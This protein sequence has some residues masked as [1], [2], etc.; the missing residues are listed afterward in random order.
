M[1]STSAATPIALPTMWEIML[2]RSS[3]LVYT[4]ICRSLSFVLLCLC[5]VIPPY[6]FFKN[7]SKHITNL[8]FCQPHFCFGRS[9]L[10]CIA[11]TS[12]MIGMMTTARPSAIAYSA[13]LMGVNSN[14]LARKGTS[15]TSVVSTRETIIAP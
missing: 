10:R 2:N 11:F 7:R 12:S 3:P 9:N 13:R 4:G 5:I 15:M 8:H 1:H 14:A 6:R